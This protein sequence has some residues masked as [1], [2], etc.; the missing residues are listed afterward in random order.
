[1]PGGHPPAQAAAPSRPSAGAEGGACRPACHRPHCSCACVHPRA[2]S[3]RPGILLA[4][5]GWPWFAVGPV[6]GYGLLLARFVALGCERARGEGWKCG[7]VGRGACHARGTLH[8]AMLPCTAPPLPSQ[9]KL[10]PSPLLRSAALWRCRRAWCAC[11][12][13]GTASPLWGAW[14]RSSSCGF[15]TTA[16]SAWSAKVRGTA[17]AVQGCGAA[18]CCIASTSFRC[19]APPISPCASPASEGA[20]AQAVAHVLA[21][22][23]QSHA[24]PPARAGSPT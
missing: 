24:S 9:T 15:R 1:M 22:L 11:R 2:P 20:K 13:G 6:P 5:V 7:R 19:A 14:R 3:A 12:A 10:R 4:A 23:A 17:R 18:W 16:S 21:A 8:S